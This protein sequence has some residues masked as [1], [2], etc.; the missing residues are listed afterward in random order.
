MLSDLLSRGFHRNQRVIQQQADG[1]DH[2]AS[3]TQAEYNVNCFNWVVGHI[4]DGRSRL[5]ERYG[6]DPVI[7]DER[8]SRYRRES[9]PIT[10]DGSDVVA[11]EDLMAML[12]RSQDAIEAWLGEV[13]DSW[14]AEEVDVGDGR[15]AS[16]GAQI[17]FVYFHDTYHTGQTD[18][19]RQMS[20]MSDKVI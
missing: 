3:L 2:A 19:L 17:M 4:V 14:L 9:D 11:F 7:A 10:A 12:G 20:G 6:R 8:G 15:T 16:R 5:L 18:L 1:I 13:D